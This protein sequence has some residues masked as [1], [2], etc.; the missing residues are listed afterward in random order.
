M[1]SAPAVPVSTSIDSLPV[2]YLISIS[3]APSTCHS[4]ARL[5]FLSI[6]Q[7]VLTLPAML[8]CIRLR[9]IVISY[10]SF[11]FESAS[12]CVCLHVS[13]HITC[14]SESFIAPWIVTCKGYQSIHLAQSRKVQTQRKCDAHASRLYV[15]W[16]GS[17]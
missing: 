2:E 11:S 16:Y 12:C 10:Y 3:S 7:R 15:S 13:L 4:S 1:P 6:E 17:V 8:T 9:R 14:H 5:R